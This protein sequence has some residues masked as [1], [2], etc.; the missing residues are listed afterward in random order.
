MIIDD[1]FEYKGFRIHC[2]AEASRNGRFSAGLVITRVT[3]ERLLERHFPRI[4][5]FSSRREA[6]EHVRQVA[7]AWIDAQEVP[8]ASIPP[9]TT[10]PVVAH[11]NSRNAPIPLSPPNRSH[12]PAPGL[13]H[14]R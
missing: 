6:C 14:E 7:M 12:R 10:A 2:L 3:P 4:A 13:R 9:A 8:I 5:S 11:V 1:G